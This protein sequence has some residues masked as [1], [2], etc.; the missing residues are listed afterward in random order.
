ML[1]SS[2][3]M[4]SSIFV[5]PRELAPFATGAR[6]PQVCDRSGLQYRPG[7]GDRKLMQQMAGER[8]AAILRQSSRR[9]RALRATVA[10]SH[11]SR[12]AA[13]TTHC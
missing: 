11:D 4:R 7:D 6:N 5:K 8:R 1:D 3:F 12:A 13:L 10:P 2:H 9:G